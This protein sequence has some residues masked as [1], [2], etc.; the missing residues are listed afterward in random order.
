M[1]VKAMSKLYLAGE[2]AIL[3]PNNIALICPVEKYTYL[4]IEKS[5]EMNIITSIKDK[6]NL[7]SKALNIAFKF[8][9]KKENLR[10]EYST[11]LYMNGKKM[12]L[13]SS[14]SVVVVTIK[15][16]LE[17][18]G[19]KYTKDELFLLC[20]EALKDKNG[21]MG[22]IAC[23]C[24]EQLIEYHSIDKETKKY[25]IKP[26]KCGKLLKIK[27]IWTNIQASTDDQIKN[28]KKYFENDKFIEFC[29]VSNKYTRLMI[30]AI[31][32]GNQEDLKNA[33]NNIN[34]NF[35]KLEKLTSVTIYSDKIK[36]IMGKNNNCKISGAGLGD[37]VITLN[38]ENNKSGYQLEFEV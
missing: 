21:S 22:D 12:G 13:G 8:A 3:K 27:A 2:Y 16:I 6:D 4:N 14:A 17:Y 24:Y 19:I 26:I 32:Q 15:G 25:E 33:I 31:Q 23:I 1:L 9:G 18:F 35:K 29:N 34:N 20:V 11:D 30:N 5:D 28:M 10:L 7:I 38:I 37:F 36:D